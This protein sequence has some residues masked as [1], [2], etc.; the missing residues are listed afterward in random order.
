MA[1]ELSGISRI[2][3]DVRE[4][5]SGHLPEKGMMTLKNGSSLDP[6]RG[7]LRPWL[8]CELRQGAIVISRGCCRET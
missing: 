8:R 2:G 5:Q 7:R 4:M 1:F 3:C 6:S